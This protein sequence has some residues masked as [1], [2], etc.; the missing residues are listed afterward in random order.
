[1]FDFEFFFIFQLFLLF[2]GLLLVILPFFFLNKE[3][4]FKEKLTSYEC[5]F[6]PF[7]DTRS[8]FDVQFYL[9][10]VLFLLFDLEISFLFPWVL[11]YYS[12]SFFSFFCGFLFL[13]ILILGFI[14]EWQ[15]GALDWH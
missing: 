11:L 15:N 4:F 13:F 3:I 12:I 8:P 7:E 6:E 2:F 14:Y 10:A 9:V 5:G 1:M